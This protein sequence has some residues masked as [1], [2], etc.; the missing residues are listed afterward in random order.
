MTKINDYIFNQ[1]K[2]KE[3]IKLEVSDKI[4]SSYN[5]EDYI[6]FHSSRFLHLIGYCGKGKPISIM[7]RKKL[8]FYD[9]L[10]RYPICL[11]KTTE[12][13]KIQFQIE[14]Y[15]L[16]NL[17]SKMIQHV[18]GPWD[19]RYYDIL[20]FL[21]SRKLLEVSGNNGWT[22]KITD[23][24]TETLKLLSNPEN[25]KLTQRCKL[26]RSMF[27]RYNEIKIQE[28]INKNFAFTKLV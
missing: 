11:K 21:I 25:D 18:G 20:S 28:F 22:I 9:F 26:I 4:R 1:L 3:N 6:E 7:G 17:D 19:E 14:D 16:R 5:P 15:E 13:L 24:G 12:I 8:A 23:K 10:L 2:L 27:G